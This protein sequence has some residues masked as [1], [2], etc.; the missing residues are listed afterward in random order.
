MGAVSEALFPTADG[1]SMGVSVNLAVFRS[2]R[3]P[4]P[5]DFRMAHNTGDLRFNLWR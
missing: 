2:D 1:S 5:R 4:R 3:T